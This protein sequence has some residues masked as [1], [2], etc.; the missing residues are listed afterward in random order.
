M[1]SYERNFDEKRDFIRMRV[2]S[3]AIIKVDGNS[4][5]AL[6]VDLSSNGMQLKTEAQVSLGQQVDVEIVSQH[7]QLPSLKATTEV[8]RID[9]AE[10][11][12]GSVLGLTILAMN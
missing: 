11:G 9:A 1:S 10:D 8:I 5:E 7:S 4:Q 3:K 12:Q 6:C 2:D